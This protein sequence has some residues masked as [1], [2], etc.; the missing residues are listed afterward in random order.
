MEEGEED[1]EEEGEEEGEED[2]EEEGE[3]EGEVG[4]G[5]SLFE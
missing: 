3:E 2:W 5:S 4:V 1:W